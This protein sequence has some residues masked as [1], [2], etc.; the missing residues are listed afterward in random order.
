MLKNLLKS[1]LFYLLSSK[2]CP[3]LELKTSRNLYD[4]D[5]NLIKFDELINKDDIVSLGWK[6]QNVSDSSNKYELILKR[7][8]HPEFFYLYHRPGDRIYKSIITIYS[9]GTSQSDVIVYRININTKEEL[10][11]LLKQL[12][13]EPCTK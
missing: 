9:G 10:E 13:I 12:N 5:G 7:A 8:F 1:L 6:F 3:V 2:D 11:I 4:K